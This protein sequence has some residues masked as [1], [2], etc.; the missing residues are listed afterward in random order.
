MSIAVREE[1]DMTTYNAKGTRGVPR[2]LAQN[3]AFAS[4]CLTHPAG[5]RRVW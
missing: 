5:F 1:Q 4:P 2:G 3:M